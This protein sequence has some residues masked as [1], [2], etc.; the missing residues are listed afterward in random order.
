MAPL[1]LRH[2]QV[3]T[4][5][6]VL[7]VVV[8]SVCF[9][10]AGRAVKPHS[11]QFYNWKHENKHDVCRISRQYFP[12]KLENAWLQNVEKWQTRFCGSLKETDDST[13]VWLE[14]LSAH[15]KLQA[16][17]LGRD[18]PAQALAAQQRINSLAFS[19]FVTTYD[20]GGGSKPVQETTW[21]EPLSHG[22]RHP[23]ALCNRCERGG[24]NSGS[25]APCRRCS[26][27]RAH[28]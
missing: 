8:V 4:K 9:Y 28:S 26:V 27:G 25:W 6:V 13:T 19:R 11:P 7:L 3:H 2:H 23:N 5:Y 10:A 16:S 12:S 18:S 1:R 15:D 24:A 21:I 22:L 20:C 14:A 17:H